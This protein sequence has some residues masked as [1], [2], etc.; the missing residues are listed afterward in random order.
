[1]KPGSRVLTPH[2][3]GVIFEAEITADF[4]RYT[5]T[6]RYGVRLDYNMGCGL[7]YYFYENEVK[8]E[9]YV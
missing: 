1:M 8:E 3:P 7:T 4:E 9:N 5:I 2:G 6:T